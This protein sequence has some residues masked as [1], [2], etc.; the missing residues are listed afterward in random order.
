VLIKKMFRR[1]WW[2]MTLIVVSAVV[3]CIW[4]GFWQL[5][6]RDYKRQLNARMAEQWQLAPFDLNRTPLPVD[7]AEL[8][9][10]RV[11]V[12]GTF[13]YERQIILKNDTRNQTPGV[14]LITP[15]VLEDGRAIL[16]A[17]GWLSLD[18]AA[19]ELWR[20]YDEPAGTRIV[21]LIQE[22]QQ[23][24]GAARPTAPQSEWFRVDID[25]IAVQLPY[26]LLPAFVAMLPEPGRNFYQLPVRTEPPTPYDEFMHVGYTVQWFAFAAIFGFGYIQF[27]IYD[28]R[29]Q[30]RLAAQPASVAVGPPVTVQE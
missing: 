8:E 3:F 16:V 22:S 17:R 7:L 13:D 15:L 12:Q 23:L 29:R 20:D 18:K 4:A 11:E 30:K 28:E 10:R 2:L 1:Q 5:E 24:P 9:Y 6:R 14:N 26:E 19:P 21:G 25:A 27:L